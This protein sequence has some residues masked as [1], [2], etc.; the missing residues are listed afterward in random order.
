MDTLTLSEAAELLKLPVEVRPWPDRRSPICGRF[1]MSVE[2]PSMRRGH[3]IRVYEGHCRRHSHAQ[4]NRVL[5]VSEG[6][7]LVEMWCIGTIDQG[8]DGRRR[9]LDK[10]DYLGHRYVFGFDGFSPHRAFIARTTLKAETVRDALDWLKPEPVRQA[11]L[12]GC[13]SYRQGDW[14]FFPVA[15]KPRCS[16]RLEN[17]PL[18]WPPFP[19]MRYVN[20]R[21]GSRFAE[22]KNHPLV[23]WTRHR[24]TELQVSTS[25]KVYV[26]GTVTAPDHEPLVFDGWHQAVHNRLLAGATAPN[27]GLSRRPGLID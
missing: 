6:G 1:R 14:W 26:R 11:E 10:R 19:G 15:T 9:R 20:L 12:A 5:E 25:D 7:M 27:A 18:W 3:I 23:P 21:T 4:A 2:P 8:T 17:T 22:V 24:A 16:V 13:P